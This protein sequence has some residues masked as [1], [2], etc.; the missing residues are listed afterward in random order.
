MLSEGAQSGSGIEGHA[1]GASGVS[2]ELQCGCAWRL[3]RDLPHRRDPQTV[4]PPLAFALSTL[5]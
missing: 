5:L 3:P 2:A 4:L 1:G